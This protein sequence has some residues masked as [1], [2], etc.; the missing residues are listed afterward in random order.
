MKTN[1]FL[2]QGY[3]YLVNDNNFNWFKSSNLTFNT[4]WEPKDLFLVKKGDVV[5]CVQITDQLVF[6][7]HLSNKM[8]M[9]LVGNGNQIS[10]FL[11]GNYHLLYT[12]DLFVELSPAHTPC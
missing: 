9:F 8:N 4:K 2:K 10:A 6:L 12:K 5:C 11:K 7:F 3:L 1:T